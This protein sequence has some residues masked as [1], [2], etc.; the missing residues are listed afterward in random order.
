MDQMCENFIIEKHYLFQDIR[1]VL[2]A[3]TDIFKK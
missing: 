3:Q 1:K 2:K